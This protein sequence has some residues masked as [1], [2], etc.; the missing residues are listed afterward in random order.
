MTRLLV[1]A[2]GLASVVAVARN[3][4]LLAIF[5]MLWVVALQLERIATGQDK[6]VV[7]EKPAITTMTSGG[8][9]LGPDAMM[10]GTTGEAKEGGE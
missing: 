8:M 6:L 2:F 9:G 1:T 3:D 7:A 5:C 4:Y 10:D